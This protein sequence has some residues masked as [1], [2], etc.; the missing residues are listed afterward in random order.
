MRHLGWLC[1]LLGCVVGC[2]NGPMGQASKMEE[3]KALTPDTLKWQA[4]GPEFPAGAKMAVLEGDPSMKGMFAVRMD[5]P[6]GYRIPPHWHS[7]SEH[8]TVI[9]GTFLLGMG[10]KFDE[11]AMQAY[12]PGSYIVLPA[13]MAH[14]AMSRGGSVVQISGHGPFDIHYFNAADDPRNMKK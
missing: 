11:K 2:Q 13:H 9:S 10:E 7:M 14:Y 12:P 8:I 3:H 4:V 5:A 6:N 1:V